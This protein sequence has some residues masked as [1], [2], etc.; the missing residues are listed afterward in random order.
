QERWGEAAEEYQRILSEAG[1]DLVAVTPRHAVRARWLCQSRLGTLP[2]EYLRPYRDR[3]DTQ[4]RK[5]VEQG[6]AQRNARLLRRVVEE[7]FCSRYGERALDLLGD[8][9]FERG[10]FEEADHWWG[11]IVPPARP[12][13]KLKKEAR[14][15]A[16]PALLFPDPQLDPARVRAKQL[17]ARLF[18]GEAQGHRARM[19]EALQ[20]F[21][22]QHGKSIGS[23]AGQQGLYADIL[24]AVLAEPL[25]R[26]HTE[27]TA[28]WPTFGGDAGRGA[29]VSGAKW[30]LRRICFQP[31][32]WRFS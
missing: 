7:A 4:A 32:R 10:R 29:V 6:A 14:N 18:S 15:P 2:A 24:Q 30:R 21:R 3:I 27:E 8:L 9:A 31:P 23:L 1:D 12:V 20:A 13:A 19:D 26:D 22:S 16:F 28:S 11:M 17:L 25:G 5:W